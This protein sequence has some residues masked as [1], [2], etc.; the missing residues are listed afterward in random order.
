MR[1]NT[2]QKD[3]LPTKLQFP[4]LYGNLP[5]DNCLNS[6]TC[7]NQHKKKNNFIM[8]KQHQ[9]CTRWFSKYLS[10]H[11]FWMAVLDF[12]P[13]IQ[14]VPRCYGT[15]RCNINFIKYQLEMTHALQS[16][17]TFLWRKQY[18][19]SIMNAFIPF[20]LWAKEGAYVRPPES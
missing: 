17:K 1:S 18:L 3:F 13:K 16:E 10:T 5:D 2:F 8:T 11:K 14:K 19:T 20:P 7:Y 15:N 12:Y 9:H 6:L 4:F